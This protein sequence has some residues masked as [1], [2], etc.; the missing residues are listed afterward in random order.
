MRCRGFAFREEA[1]KMDNVTISEITELFPTTPSLT[2]LCSRP[3]FRATARP[4]G[5]RNL[6]LFASNLISIH[7]DEDFRTPGGYSQ[8]NWMGVCIA[9]PKSL[10]YLRHKSLIFPQPNSR[11]VQK[12]Y[13]IFS[14]VTRVCTSYTTEYRT[15]D[16]LI[17]TLSLI[18]EALL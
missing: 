17:F 13:P 9:L 14:S 16:L 5:A 3:N 1:Q 6:K 12:P 15:F 7:F 11:G 4:A 8:K 10:P 18:E 2:I